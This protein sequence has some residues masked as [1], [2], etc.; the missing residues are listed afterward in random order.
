MHRIPRTIGLATLIAAAIACSS[1]S[2]TDPGP[3]GPGPGG[4]S[5]NAAA[6]NAYVAALGDWPTAVPAA[7]ADAPL[8]TVSLVETLAGG[9][10]LDYRCSASARNL[11]RSHPKLLAA[12]SDFD[13]LYPGAL[14]EGASVRSGR[15]A[16][17]SVARPPLT[18]RINLAIANQSRRVDNVN[19][20]TMAQAIADLQ[21]AAV[22]QQGSVDP[23][24]ADM[25]FDLSEATTFDQ[26]M[27][28]VG[29]SLAYSNPFTGAG[30]NGNIEGSMTRS[31]RTHSVV[32]KFVQE[33]FTVR[34]A[35]DLIPDAAGFV[36]PTVTAAELQ[37]LQASGRIGPDNLPVYVES[38]TF[39][40]VF[41]FTA[42]STTVATADEL[43]AAM[44]ASV[45]NY[46]GGATLSQA[47]RQILTNASYRFVVFG[48]PQ[49][50]A[51]DAIGSLDWSKYFVPAAATTAVPIAFTVKTLK[52]RQAATI[53]DDVVYNERGGCSAPVSYTV[54]VAFNRVTRT[55]GFCAACVVSAEI[56]QPGAPLSILGAGV[57]TPFEQTLNY[58]NATRTMTLAPTQKFELWSHLDT[59]GQGL[60]FGYPGGAVAGG[61]NQMKL[62]TS[63]ADRTFTVNVNAIGA[64]GQFTYTIRK[65]A[66]F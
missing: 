33:M 19:S 11:V 3:T 21:Q 59:G 6:V 16:V 57:L 39:G 54:R 20:V 17:L 2:S 25:V 42:Q 45:A 60:Q 32:V 36:A 48:G 23:V 61:V 8:P 40:R 55:S 63:G 7:R 4:G 12:G 38:V 13:A 14:L 10:L 64:G 24:R 31:V 15:P 1:D 9:D 66:N 53:Y 27:T 22:G 41:L 52:G 49:Q 18:I 30:A 62:M 50:A 35:D 5:P 37:A 26:A 46:K 65:T 51:T 58:T 44:Q 43:K 34:L 28:A 56:Q 29:V 47:H